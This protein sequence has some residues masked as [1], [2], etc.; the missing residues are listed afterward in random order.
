MLRAL[1]LTTTALIA[2]AA[3]ALAQ[4]A[5]ADR[6]EEVIVTGSQVRIA[7]PYAGGQVARGARVG[8]FGTLSQLDT[9]F[10]VT[11]YTE[12]LARNQQA[13]SVGDVLQN[14]PAVRVSKGFGNFQELYVIRGFPVYSDDM[15]YNGLYG[16][17]PRQFVAAEFL[18]RVEVFH[19]ATA[20]LN[21]AA[22]G[23]SGV[24]GAF[25][26][27]PK[28]AGNEPLTRL[29][30]GLEGGREGY[31]AAD[32]SRRF[33]TD[34]DTGL[35]LNVAR[36]DG[37]GAI[38][39]QSRTLSVVG[40]GLDRRGER[41]RLSA[42]LGWQDHRIDAPRPTVTPTGAVP[43]AP[44]ASGNFAQPW[45]YTDEEQL[46]GVV[47]GELDLT[48]DV[49][50]WAAFG[51]RSGEESNV[52]ANP[53][54]A[55]DGTTSAYRFDNTRE[56]TVWSGDVGVR[57]D[58][59]TGSVDHRL[60]ASASQ[61]RSKSENAYAFS[62]FAGFAS[63][64]SN[65][66]AVAPPV[67]DFFVGGD[68]A[69]P[70]VT[71]RVDNTSVALADMMT[72]M[73]GRLLLTVGA[74][75]QS[76]ETRTYAYGSGVPAP[77][78]E[79]DAVT[80]VLA[81][82]YKPSEWISLYANYAEALVPGQIAPEVVGGVQIDNRGEVLDPFLGEQMEVGLK[83]DVGRFGGSV[84]LFRTTLQ[85]A[86]VENG[87]FGT[88]GEQRNQGLEIAFFGEPRDGLR[89]LGGWTLLD[90]ELTET[91]GGALDGR[92][93][94]GAPELQGNVNV[95]WDVPAVTGLT[96][97]GR[98]VYTGEQEVNATNTVQLDSWTRLDA[99]V[100]YA[101]EASGRPL[102]VRARVE[103]LAD[104]DQWVAVGGFPGAN[105]LTLGAPRT[106]SLSISAEF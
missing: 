33:G 26:L 7:A 90:A 59:T 93:P 79:S 30:L 69:N 1:A 85:S 58:L 68:L 60:V 44:D 101:F 83:Y 94:I 24:G 18:E 35:R 48:P 39:D 96:L 53:A 5:A 10:A 71:E 54:A 41:A 19:G 49:S 80:P 13:R 88:N 100:R 89:V 22:P 46:F 50:A 42:D 47:R 66:V 45:T 20:F 70:G 14:D 6:L 63:S 31:A 82:V 74:R 2:F 43:A 8:L 17:L 81:V 34:G 32:V 73:D 91:A 28:R 55:P 105:Y 95:E 87:R 23:G 103:N 36:R 98:L 38:D 65:P 75:H 57:A 52:L 51:G 4:D 92:A 77:A 9:P 84:S 25:N 12:E 104:E 72:F 61:V 106:L 97:E 3:P 27:T 15:T 64:L 102:T 99:G 78:Y 21:G 86:F 16:I 11:A 40:L 29:T 76:I 62:N 37:E 67:P 56:D